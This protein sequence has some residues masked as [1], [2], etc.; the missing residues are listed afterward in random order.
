MDRNVFSSKSSQR[1]R[2]MV[3]VNR[4]NTIYSRL[5]TYDRFDL[6]ILHF[7]FSY[8]EK[9]NRFSICCSSQS[10][11]CK[12]NSLLNKTTYRILN[13]P[14]FCQL[15]IKKILFFILILLPFSFV[16]NTRNIL[17]KKILDLYI[18]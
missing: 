3:D 11:R 13:F 9:S 6:I 17:S 14:N 2:D 1:Q 7:R 12:T 15:I 18:Q 5:I 10:T 4:R 16:N 8:T